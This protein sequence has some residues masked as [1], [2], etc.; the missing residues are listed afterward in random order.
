M[1]QNPLFWI[2][3][4]IRSRIPAIVMMTG[5][6]ILHSVLCVLFAL[7]SRNVIDSAVAGD[8]SGFQ[9]ACLSQCA[10]IAGILLT[11]LAVRYFRDTIQA[12]LDRDWKK[13]LLNR[14]LH[15]EYNAVSS[16]HSAE[17]LNRLN[18]DVNKVN[19]AILTL[20]P[21]AVSML[22]RLIAAVAVLGALELRFTL[23][24][25]SLGA[26]V[27]LFSSLMRGKLKNLNKEVSRHDG[28]VSAFIQETLEKLLIVQAMNL[29]D[30]IERRA[31][32]LLAKR[33]RVQRRR[34]N[35]SLWANMGVAMMSYG[36]AFL[37][38]GW[39]GYK[40]MMGAMTF[41]ALTAVI[42]L[43]NQ[44]QAPF[45]GLTGVMP[46]Y[47]AMIASGERLM[48][49]EEIPDESGARE[50]DPRELYAGMSAI[51]AE[52]LSFSYDR[53]AV[54]E[55]VSFSLPKGSF[56]VMTGA[57]GIGKS[58]ILKLLLGIFSPREGRLYLDCNGK[59][60][61]LNRR[62]RGLFAYVPQ[63]NLLFSGTI[64]ENLT[65][66]KPDASESE[67]QQAI[68]VSAMDEYL[69][70]LPLGL[71]T[72]IGESAAG[73]SEGQAQRL[74]I[75]RA[76]LSGAPV[77]LLDEC[78]SALDVETERKVLTRLR[79]LEDRTCIAVTHRDAAI[80]LCDV[81]LEI[82]NGKIF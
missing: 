61:M 46:Q 52:K 8:R 77:L 68:F 6:Q 44:L 5:A 27:V 69:S 21:N 33:Y 22:T 58:T 39:C 71:D 54:L 15:G 7:A 11:L 23:L 45:V 55:N 13:R 75:A 26:I 37:A 74:S 65:I 49:L 20:F 40:M 60:I 43:V 41:G 24:I 30:E 28:K 3:K 76:I 80:G 50:E 9:R 66:V 73:L 81:H 38:L 48:E 34:K 16:Y 1:K 57:S 31:D 67:I 51:C 36:A 78:T 62:T 82:K 53:D 35:A 70:Q 32:V 59:N 19:E 14:L 47:A 56:T 18:Q 64:R 29:E 4:Q 42:Q 63:G 12:K 72:E 17:M 79:N 10:I 2:L 25:L